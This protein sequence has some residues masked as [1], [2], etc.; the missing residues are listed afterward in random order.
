MPRKDIMLASTADAKRI[1]ALGDKFFAQ[2]KLNGIRC[3][4]RWNGEKAELISSGGN[5]FN[6]L[7]HINKALEEEYADSTHKPS[8]DGELYCHKMPFEEII[9]RVKRDYPHP[10]SESIQYHIFDFKHTSMQYERLQMITDSFSEGSCLVGIK[11]ILLDK[12]MLCLNTFRP[13]S[14]SQWYRETRKVSITIFAWFHRMIIELRLYS[15]R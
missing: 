4:V 9:S 8:P 15:S 10:D 1:A 7:P 12:S 6:S 14:S 5:V 2:P 13:I 11:S 3:W